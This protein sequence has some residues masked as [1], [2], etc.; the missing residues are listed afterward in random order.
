MRTS[1]GHPNCSKQ[2]RNAIPRLG[3]RYT[4]QLTPDV[5]KFILAYAQASVE[6]GRYDQATAQLGYLESLT[7]RYVPPA[8]IR[9]LESELDSAEREQLPQEKAHLN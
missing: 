6:A 5:P 4:A 9:Q 1:L 8:M 2:Y 7:S 3:F